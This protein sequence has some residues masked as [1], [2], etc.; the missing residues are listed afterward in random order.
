MQSIR[1]SNSSIDLEEI[2]G[3]L[4]DESRRLKSLKNTRTYS[5]NSYN[6][7]SYI[8]S[9]NSST[10]KSPSDYSNNIEMSM[11]TNNINKATTKAYSN[12]KKPP[13]K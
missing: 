8:R 6:S 3:Q 11:Q 9:S 7:N 1:T 13:N 12:I 2:I 5:N 4:L 10:L